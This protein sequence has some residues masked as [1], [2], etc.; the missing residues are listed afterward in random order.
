MGGGGGYDQ[1]EEV[2][3]DE[4]VRERERERERERRENWRAKESS[5]NHRRCAA[6]ACFVE[7]PAP[8]ELLEIDSH[9]SPARTRVRSC[10]A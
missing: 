8:F 1:R 10:G 3:R 7:H 4:R 5:T 2:E 9:I 6:A